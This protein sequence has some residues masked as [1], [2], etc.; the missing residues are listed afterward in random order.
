MDPL[1]AIITLLRPKAVLSKLI[2]GAGSWGVRYEEFGHPSFALVLNGSCWLAV[3]GGSPAQLQ[4]GDF[5]FLPRTP[6]FTLSSD[7]KTEP[8][9][10][11]PGSYSEHVSIVKHGD[12][13]A[14]P[15]VLL[16]GGYFAFDQVNAPMLLDQLPDLVHI[17]SS[18]AGIDSIS[19]IIKL[20]DKEARGEGAGRDLILERLVE[21]M[22]L[23][24]LRSTD[25]EIQ[26]A[27]LLAGLRDLAIAA[28]LRTM[29]ADVSHN[30]SV[31]EL[32]RRAGMS[33]S[34]FA[35]RFAKTVG[36]TPIDY[37]LQLRM[38]LAKDMLRREKRSLSE[39]ADFIGYQ[40]T[41]AFS[42]A[43]RRNTGV[44]PG[45]FARNFAGMHR[46]IYQR[47]RTL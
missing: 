30:W 38:A 14:E 21:V 8:V 7:L 4:T 17:R 5:V 42:T 31:A 24:A 34:S 26:K 16:Q 27:G 43:F 2:S 39:V 15:S 45:A 23:E 22:L 29:H 20:I 40:S 10:V 36:S 19:Q 25:A 18:D 1:A 46:A 35:D 41:S 33:R 11:S 37:L 32:G 44:S 9:L 13:T 47:S 6:G 3:E 28:A 12:E